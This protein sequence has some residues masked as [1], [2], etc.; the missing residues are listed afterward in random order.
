MGRT[1]VFLI[2]N[3]DLTALEIAFQYKN[4]WQ[5]ELSF[6]WIKQHL[7]VKF[8]GEGAENVLGIQIFAAIIA[9]CLVAIVVQDLKLGYSTYE[10]LQILGASP[11]EKTPLKKLLT[12][13]DYK[14]VKQLNDKQFKINFD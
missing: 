11:L 3:V 4:R 9:Y 5:V 8:F 10:I 12:K 13:L 2:N 7:K 14:D 1:F 6:K